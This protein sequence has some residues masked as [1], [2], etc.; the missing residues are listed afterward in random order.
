MI[1]ANIIN[2]V[3]S[4]SALLANQ[5]NIAFFKEEGYEDPD[6]FLNSLGVD[7]NLVLGGVFGGNVKEV[8]SGG[9]S[10]LENEN[11]DN[12]VSFIFKNSPASAS[13]SSDSRIFEHPLEYNVGD[14]S[15]DGRARNYIADHSI[16]LPETFNCVLYLPPVLYS[17]VVEEIDDLNKKKTL[18]R[19]ITKGKTYRNMVLFRYEKPLTPDRL[20]RMP[21]TLHFKEIQLRYPKSEVSKNPSDSSGGR[22][23]AQ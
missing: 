19:I 11:F 2:L 1:T 18:L 10:G 7:S 12:A 21:V 13:G 22:N 20:Y 23:V 5:K 9:K 14:F 8:L 15:K 16:M 4:A 3:K 17:S 6:G